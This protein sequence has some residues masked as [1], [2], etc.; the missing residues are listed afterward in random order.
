MRHKLDL[1]WLVPVLTMAS[2][3]LMLQGAYTQSKPTV[4][5][6][7][8]TWAPY[9]A[10]RNADPKLAP[11]AATPLAIKAAYVKEYEAKRA[12]DAAA[13]ARGEQLANGA[14]SCMP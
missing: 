14:I 2:C 5:D 7:N 13:T 9:R 4:P 3:A 12:A 10:G 11:P 6:F 1:F 8:G